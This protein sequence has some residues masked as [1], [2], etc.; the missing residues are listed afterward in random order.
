MKKPSK[1]ES[2]A[3]QVLLGLVELYLE[4]NKPIG[5]NTLKEHGFQG[6]SSATIRN[7]FVELEKQGF[8]QQPHSSGGRIPTNE[9]FRLYAAHALSSPQP[10]PGIEE[11][12]ADLELGESR[13][14][15]RYLQKSA[16]KLSAL[17]E[18]AVFLTSVRFDH[19]FILDIKLVG[20]DPDR[21]LCVMVTDFGQIFT[22]VLPI[23]QKLSAFSLKRI[24]SHIQWRIKGGEKPENLTPDEQTLAQYFYNEIMVRYLVRYSNFSDEDVY[25]TGFSTLLSYPEFNDPVA[26]ATGLSLFENPAHMRLLLNDCVREGSLRYWIGSDLAPYASAAQ[27]CSVI[28]VPYHVG[29]TAAGAIGILG[30][31]RMHY[32]SLFATLQF[33]A[34]GL[35]KSLTKSL[36]KFKLSFRQP[37]S[38]SPYTQIDQAAQHLLEIKE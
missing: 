10:E 36:V 4:T 30:P 27:G 18:Y 1:K 33:F 25:R 16:E 6:L 22:E 35:S 28:A 17:T 24:E 31:C 19:D 2:R 9:A 8:L 15:A 21:L 38:T 3:H 37:R 26:L 7:Y 34:D 11:K 5:S 32:R 14:L 29:Q 20:I 23:D 13:N 12:L